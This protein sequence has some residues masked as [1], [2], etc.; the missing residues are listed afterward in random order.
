VSEQPNTWD[1]PNADPLADLQAAMRK[2]RDGGVHHVV[3]SAS[4][5]RTQRYLDGRRVHDEQ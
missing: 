2:M 4:G 3:L 5:P 1:H